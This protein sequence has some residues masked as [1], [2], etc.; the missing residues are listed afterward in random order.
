MVGS[1]LGIVPLEALPDFPR[2]NPDDGILY[3]F[4]HRRAAKDSMRN[5][6]FLKLGFIL[7]HGAIHH[8]TQKAAA[9][10]RRQKSLAL[11]NGIQV[12]TDVALGNAVVRPKRLRR[13][14]SRGGMTG[15]G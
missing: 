4:D 9:P 11:E 2:T 5:G 3:P 10:A 14:R 12:F 6:A 7:C 13:S 15:H 1:V 8:V